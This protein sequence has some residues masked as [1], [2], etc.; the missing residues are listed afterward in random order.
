MSR[1]IEKL[2]FVTGGISQPM[3]FRTSRAEPVKPQMLLIA[4]IQKPESI[5]SLTDY[6]DKADAVL[7]HTAQASPVTAFFTKVAKALPDIPWGCWLQEADDKTMEKAVESGCDFVAF[8]T[9]SRVFSTGKNDKDDKLG[10]ILHVESSLNDGLLRAINSLPVD[11][12]FVESNDSLD[13]YGL[14]G[15]QRLSGMVSK[16]LL[17]TV[18]PDVAGA[19][20]KA[21]WEAG[22]DG[23]VI[24]I[25]A[26]QKSGLLEQL[27]QEISKFASSVRK[28]GKTE[29][30]V[31]YS[32][33]GKETDIE[34]EEEEYEE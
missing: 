32:I 6:I 1:L 27:R 33:E 20:L 28:R 5:D 24:E 15:L 13:W 23:V 29:A 11:A 25:S 8:T 3:G 21:L 16:P 4:S 30:L 18:P 22:V 9:A 14:M 10:R 34:P 26:G 12:I 31:P 7:L 17:A 19:E 2:N